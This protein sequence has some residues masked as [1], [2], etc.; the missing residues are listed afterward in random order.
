MGHLAVLLIT[1]L[2]RIA[3]FCNEQRHSA[4]ASVNILATYTNECLDI[5]FQTAIDCVA[6][7]WKMQTRHVYLCRAVKEHCWRRQYHLAMSEQC[8]VK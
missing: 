7:V 2:L 5:A 1:R 8:S 3:S 4:S 6:S